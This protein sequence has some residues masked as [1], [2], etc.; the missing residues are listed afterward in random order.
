M[1]KAKE[2]HTHS[3]LFRHYDKNQG[4]HC[5]AQTCYS[6]RTHMTQTKRQVGLDEFLP[7]PPKNQW[8][9]SEDRGNQVLGGLKKS[10]LLPQTLMLNGG[11]GDRT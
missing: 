11:G 6:F 8:N 3:S 4:R 5:L 9:K 1:K 7:P 10:K 2:G